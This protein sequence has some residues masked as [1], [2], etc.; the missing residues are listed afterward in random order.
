MISVGLGQAEGMDTVTVVRRAISAC[1]SQM[2][3]RT[4]QAG[5]VFAGAGFDH[6]LM[7][8]TINNGLPGMELIGCTT[9]GNFS[10]AYG[11]SDDAITLMTFASDGIE[12]ST[13]VGRD[14]SGGCET[15]VGEAV[16]TAR[17]HVSGAPALC[18]TFPATY[19]VQAAPLLKKLSSNL[20]ADCPVFGGGAGTHEIEHGDVLQFY[21]S[22]VL[23]DAIPILLMSGPVEHAFSIANSWR[24]LGKKVVVTEAQG[25]LVRRIDG[26]KAV[27]FYRH[28]LG[29]HDEPAPEFILAVY[30]HGSDEYYIRIPAEYHG[31][32]SI[33]FSESVPE[34]A[35]VQLTE[36]VRDDLIR[37]TLTTTERMTSAAQGWDPAFALAFS[38][39]FRKAILGTQAERELQILQEN[40]PPH[41]PI[42]GFH[43]FGEIAPLA[44]GGQSMAHAATLVTLLVGPKSGDASPGMASSLD[45]AARSGIGG[46]ERRTAFLE[47]KLRRS[48]AYR[49]RLEA[50]RDFSSRMHL[51]IMAEINEAREKLQRKE[52]ELRRSEEKFRRI[53]QTAGEGFV[54]M[55]ETFTVTDTNDAYCRMVGYPRADILGTSYVELAT[56]EFRKYLNANR[57]ELLAQEYRRLEGTLV[58]SDGHHVPV[59]IH[60]NTLRDDQGA[61]IGNMAF[62]TDMTEQKNALALAGE[63]QRSLLPQE[64][65]KVPGLDVAGRNVSCEEVGGDYY[66]FFWQQRPSRSSFSVAVGDVTGHGVDAALLMSSARA[67][68]RVHASQS[69]SMAEI[70]GAMNRHLAEDVKETGRFMTLFYLTVEPDL[71]GMHWVSAG[72]DPAIVYDPA[73]DAFEDLKGSGIPLGIDKRFPYQPSRRADLRDGQVIAIGTD[74]IWEYWSNRGEQFGKERLKAVLRQHAAAPAAHILNE[75]YTSLDDFGKGKKPKDDITLVIVKIRKEGD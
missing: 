20:G 30:E 60:S 33:T 47:R 15:A 31:D 27:E 72:H 16:K 39:G 5:M 29:H 51:R 19:G 23:T 54:L 75:V 56:P 32:G 52:A 69:E 66:D 73:T 44:P 42:L 53:V 55:D 3:G 74:G 7:L 59:L 61:A 45:D 17:E 25:P 35:T 36:A 28:Y 12:I 6:Q 34:G 22:E 70:V 41:L 14:L 68:L 38:C 48:E 24:P 40:L 1:R 8:D 26:R 13:G 71:N 43:S 46:L 63:V 65:P 67:S 57:D 37:D 18:L 10:T 21:G 62:I 50:M 9:A 49:K 4:P 11:V 64:S 2:A 58:A